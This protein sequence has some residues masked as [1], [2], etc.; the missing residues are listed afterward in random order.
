MSRMLMK[1]IASSAMNFL[2]QGTKIGAVTFLTLN[3][4]GGFVVCYG[5]SMEPTLRTRDILLTEHISPRLKRIDIG[6]VVVARSPQDQRCVC[7]RVVAGPGDSVLFRNETFT[8]PEDCVWLEGDNKGNSNDS[9]YYGPVPYSMVRRRCF[10]KVWPELDLSLRPGT[11][12]FSE[13]TPEMQQKI[14][15][16][17]EEQPGKEEVLRKNQQQRDSLEQRVSG[18]NNRLC[19]KANDERVEMFSL[20]KSSDSV[21]S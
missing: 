3:Y 9:R 21:V 19:D 11:G 6:D 4:V 13:T 17:E 15:C 5:P 12:Y 7:K 20:M 8:V 18:L 1:K 14:V 16:R 10:C 2:I